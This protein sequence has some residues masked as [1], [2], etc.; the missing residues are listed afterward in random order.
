MSETKST[1]SE[2][3]T[4]NKTR[5]YSAPFDVLRLKCDEHLRSWVV[6]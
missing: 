2:R 3:A 6:D 1:E 4:Q 5:R